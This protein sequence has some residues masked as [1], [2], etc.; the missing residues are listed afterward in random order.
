MIKSDKTD[1][2]NSVNKTTDA[3]QK[4]LMQRIDEQTIEVSKVTA[5]AQAHRDT[6]QEVYN[7]KLGKIKDVCAQYFSKYEKHLMH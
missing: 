4:K 2:M 7:E 3:L 6:L 5:Q 1:V